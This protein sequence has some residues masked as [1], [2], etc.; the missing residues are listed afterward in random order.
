MFLLETL[1]QKNIMN[2]TFAYTH[3]LSNL[4][5]P[6]DHRSEA[7]REEIL[8]FLNLRNDQLEKFK[9]Y[10]RGYDARNKS[11]IHFIYTLDLLFSSD[12]DT[13][14][15]AKKYHLQNAPGYGI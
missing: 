13:T 15:L 8:S 9:V 3:R 7:L 2:E 12:V 5:L 6:L 10:R 4:K 14:A 11:N 1:K